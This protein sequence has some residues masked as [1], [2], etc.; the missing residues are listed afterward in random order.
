MDN[1]M[2]KELIDIGERAK[3]IREKAMLTQREFGIMYKIP[4]STIANFELGRVNNAVLYD[5][6][7]RIERG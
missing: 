4:A 5:Y 7:L 2:R 1:D 6:Y 3:K